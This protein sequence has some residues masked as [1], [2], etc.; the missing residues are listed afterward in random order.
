VDPAGVRFS[1]AA[2]AT[3][4]ESP[5]RLALDLAPDPTVVPAH[6]GTHD[7]HEHGWFPR[8]DDPLDRAPVAEE[9]FGLGGSSHVLGSQADEAGLR[10]DDGI[11]LPRIAGNRRVLG[12]DDPS[13]RSHFRDPAR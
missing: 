9:A 4:E 10:T 5:A 13:A 1:M 7:L 2:V 12:Q 8:P 6:L 11:A 3:L